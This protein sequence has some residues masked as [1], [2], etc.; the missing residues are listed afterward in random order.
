MWT[1]TILH[2]DMDSFFVEV[3][4]LEAPALRG[5]AV[6]V[7]GTGPRGVIASASYEARRHGVRSA[8]PTATALKMCPSLIVVP[9]SHRKYADVSTQVFAIF[10]S[11]TPV[12]EGLSLDEAFLDVGGLRHH[13]ETPVGVA[14]MVRE[15]LRTELGLPASVGV[16]SNKLLAKLASEMA[17]PDGL[18]H[19]PHSTQDEFL[20]PLPATALPG[21][22]P[23]TIAALQRLGVVTIGDIAELPEEV[24]IGNLG[25]V[26]G[27]TLR[28][29]AAGVDERGV[30]PDAEA[31]SISAEETYP[32]DLQGRD[33]MEAAL[34]A[35]AHRLVGRLR[36]AGLAGR[37]VTL[38]V[39]YPDFETVTRSRTGV[40]STDS[41]RELY[42]TA[43]ELLDELRPTRGVRLL[44]LGVTGMEPTEGHRQLRIDTSPEWERVEDT[45]AR[46]RSRFGE[47]A[48]TPA[49]LID[50]P[51]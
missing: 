19:V 9:P 28:S 46:V 8:Q 25:G 22:G 36:R 42:H 30:E 31:K 20:G 40:T 7:G 2:V 34:L 3:E 5:V 27:R 32:T 35:L 1:E 11:I 33:V 23:A 10:R 6:A 45:V 38:K 17:K 43:V 47:D 13:H 26:V 49:R 29:L 21:V 24:L 15:R 4:R 51:P 39:R 37:T 18:R 41:W 12:V 50:G 16:A 14:V 44:G 48:V